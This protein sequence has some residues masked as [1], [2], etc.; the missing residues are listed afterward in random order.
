MYKVVL[1]EGDGAGGG[2]QVDPYPQEE[3]TFKIPI[4]L[5]GLIEVIAECKQVLRSHLFY[6][7]KIIALELS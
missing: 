3:T 6:S 4:A 1:R 7:G 2:G 5:L